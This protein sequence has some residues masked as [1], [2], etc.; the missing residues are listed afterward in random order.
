MVNVETDVLIIGGGPSGLAAAIAAKEAGVEHVTVIEKMG[1]L[2]GNGKFAMNLFDVYNSKAQKENGVEDSKEQFLADKANAGESP[3]RL[4]IWAEEA[5]RM[6][7]WLRSI[8][9]DI[10]YNF[11]GRSHLI[12]ESRYAG[13]EILRTF[14]K[15]A[16]ELGVDVRLETQGGEFVFEDNRVKGVQVNYKGRDYLI[17]ADAVVLAT[18]GFSNNKELLAEYAPGHEVLNTSNPGGT[19]GDYVKPLEAL[20]IKFSNMDKI[21]AAPSVLTF[22]RQML[23]NS[24]AGSIYL[25]ELGAR[26]MNERA[27]GLP[28]ARVVKDQPNEVVWLLVDS[29]KEENFPN[30]KRQIK[31][32]RF[33]KADTLE[34]LAEKIGVPANKLVNEIS[35]YNEHAIAKTEDIYGLVPERPF[36][37]EGP[38]YAVTI[39]PVVHMTKGGI[40]TDSSANVLLE[41]DTPIANLFAAG[42]ATWQSGALSQ[43]IIWGRLAGQNASKLV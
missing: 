10:T 31:E 8:D 33:I 23:T 14:E 16:E 43:S 25:N 20:N 18:G 15:L 12:T 5:G 9:V 3:E 32:N 30:V 28:A 19:T 24:D 7:E 36:E 27:R 42:E 29:L 2:S 4:E 13:A 1:T 41:D 26:F 21:M 38:Y 22:Y 11:N 39:E 34:N 17:N 40:V 37:T 6:D 35:D